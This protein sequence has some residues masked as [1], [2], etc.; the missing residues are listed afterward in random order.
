MSVVEQPSHPER[1]ERTSGM[2]GRETKGRR[3]ARKITLLQA[4]G[5]YRKDTYSEDS[6]PNSRNNGRIILPPTNRDF[7]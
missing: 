1:A 7:K 6:S 4:E 3:F 5:K 2:R